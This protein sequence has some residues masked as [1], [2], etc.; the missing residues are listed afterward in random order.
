[1][2]L[3]RLFAEEVIDAEDRFLCEDFVKGLVERFGRGQIAP[4]RL[5]QNYPR[6]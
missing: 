1:M 4:E 3:H 5:F 2:F 6:R